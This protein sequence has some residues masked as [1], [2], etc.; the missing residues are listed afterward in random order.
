[1]SRTAEP[2]AE[3]PVKVKGVKP[4]VSMVIQVP[5]AALGPSVKP[6]PWRMMASLSMTIA[7]ATR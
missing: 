1:M 4:V 3:V 5:S 2:R 7:V 6:M